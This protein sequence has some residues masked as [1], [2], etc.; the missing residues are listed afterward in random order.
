[1]RI[2]FIADANSIH[3]RRWIEYFCK[4]EN[5]VFIL[6]TGRNP[7]PIE[8]VEVYDL[9]TGKTVTADSVVIKNKRDLRSLLTGALNNKIGNSII[10]TMKKLYENAFISRARAIYH[11]FRLLGRARAMVKKLQP[12]LVHC[13]RLP[14]EGYIGGLV[15]YH[16][17]VIS[18][19][20]CDLVLFARRYFI[21]RWLTHKALSQA[22]L[23]FA[24]NTRDKYFATIFGF[25]PSKPNVVMLG[26][27]GLKSDEFPLYHK[28][29]SYKKVLGI[30]PDT[31]LLLSPRGF[32]SP[33]TNTEALILALPQVI[34][35]FPNTLCILI[36]NKRSPGYLKLKAM[37]EKLG[38]E[39]Y[40]QFVN[41]LKHP[42]FLNYLAASDIMISVS[43]Y[44]GT[45]IS[46]LEGMA[47]GVI[48]IT[49]DDL[50]QQEW[51]TDGWNGYLFNPR[52]TE[53]I[54]AVIIKALENKDNFE[55]MRKRNWDIVRERAD[56]YENMKIAEGLY[57]KLVEGSLHQK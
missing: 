51:I 8:G 40:C 26:T 57:C 15:G 10:W 41:L 33:F 19:W 44:D 38:I 48:Q 25:S 52:D 45:S 1:M 34:K 37:A 32:T 54:A 9:Y 42:D 20:G 36:G 18:S 39:K 31:N 30:A 5:E 21:F 46:M 49:S 24:D 16:P 4:P 2:C 35:R 29:S 13:L 23:F 6:S 55:I 43:L 53:N 11:I 3:A 27:G 28:D 7:E 56:Y 14:L 17:L 22:D 47:C 50:P 12:D